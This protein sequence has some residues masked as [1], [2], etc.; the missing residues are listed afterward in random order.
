MAHRPRREGAQREKIDVTVMVGPQ[1]TCNHAACHVADVIKRQADNRRE[2]VL[3]LSAGST[4]IGVYKELVRLH[5]EEGLDFGSV[6]VF[7]LGE[8]YPSDPKSP[9]SC[10]QYL[11]EHLL[12]KVN[13]PP[14]QVHLLNGAVTP[15]DVDS[16][17]IEYD[18]AIDRA[19]GFDLALLSI[20]KSGQIAFSE[21]GAS[22]RSP[23]RPVFLD[24]ELRK[25]CS[26]CIFW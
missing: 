23:T 25:G 1:Q 4:C 19:G 2:A 6:R 11:R 17:C 10:R 26:E 7:G 5:R 9:Q 12:D 21:A 15:M 13:I 22:V 18:R 16:H 20:G 8:F 24:Y 14:D 3:A